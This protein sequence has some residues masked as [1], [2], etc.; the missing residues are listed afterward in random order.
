[1]PQQQSRFAL[2]SMPAS[3]LRLVFWRRA[4]ILCA[5]GLAAD[6]TSAAGPSYS[7]RSRMLRFSFALLLLVQA[8]RFTYSDIDRAAS[9]DALV[10]RYPHSSRVGET[11]YV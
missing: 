3:S 2:A 5:P 9:L 11:I 7:C 10:R 8:S 6:G 1:M 4:I